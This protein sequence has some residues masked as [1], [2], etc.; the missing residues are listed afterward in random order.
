M[1]IM[2]GLGF[3]GSYGNAMTTDVSNA[4]LQCIRKRL[5]S[6]MGDKLILLTYTKNEKMHISQ[7]AMLL[8]E[9]VMAEKQSGTMNENSR[10]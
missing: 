5:Y 2:R 10:I 3:A 9:M 1:K 8:Y 6:I 7:N 4:V